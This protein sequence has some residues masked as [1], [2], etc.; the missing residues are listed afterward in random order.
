MILILLAAASSPTET[1]RAF[2]ERIYAS[3]R[4]ENFNPFEHSE[5]VFAP[6]LNAEINED[7][8][9]ARGEVGF[10]DG[11]PI[12]SC[13]DTGGMR[14]RVVSVARSGASATAHI[15]VTWSGT[16]DRRDIKL[17]LVRTSAG[18]RIA[19]VGSADEPSLL[20]D[21]EAANRKARK[22]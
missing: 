9:L 21:L 12:C 14:S 15:V 3:Y 20:K 7:A 8:R 16:T 5:R 18:W 17:N 4:N 13:Q 22:H 11:D 19:D 6:K 2:V 10:L 1:P